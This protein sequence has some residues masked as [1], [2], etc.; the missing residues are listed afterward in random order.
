MNGLIPSDIMDW[1]YEEL[2][3]IDNKL[4]ENVCSK[5]EC[6]DIPNEAPTPP[7]V[8]KDTIYHASLCSYALS[9]T[10]E[11]RDDFLSY[12]KHSFNELSISVNG[13]LLIII[14]GNTVYIT[15]AF[16]GRS[17]SKMHMYYNVYLL[18]VAIK[19]YLYDIYVD[20]LIK[21]NN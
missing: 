18:I 13:T 16:K 1:C 8:N 7:L 2:D 20:C 4:K 12:H 3:T 10:N 11:S 15:L 21:G 5:V 17:L 19:N 14:Q 6:E 9:T